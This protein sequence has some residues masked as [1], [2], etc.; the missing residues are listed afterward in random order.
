MPR[1]TLIFGNGLGMALAPQAY[2]LD[3]ALR[4]IWEDNAFLSGEQKGLIQACLPEGTEFDRPSDENDLD[5]LQRVLS[6]CDFLDEFD[7]VEGAHWLSEHGRSFP[8]AIRRF[9]HQVAACFHATGFELPEDFT[10]PL[11]DFLHNTKSHV[12]TL[13]YDPL[14]YDCFLE[15]NVLAGYRGDLIDGITNYGFQKENL[16]RHHPDNLGWYLHLHGSP[17]FYD[18][19]NGRVKKLPRGRLNEAVVESTHLVLT[20]V[21]HKASIISTSP[22]LSEYWKFLARALTESEEVLL[23]GYSGYDSHLNSFISRR[24]NGFE[25][26]VVEWIG[27]QPDNDRDAFWSERLRAQV[28]VERHNSILDFSAW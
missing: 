1:K 20:H 19:P 15:R 5:V 11:C 13:N 8:P 21:R 7:D 28:A 27:A 25:L 10:I 6:A 14:L 4:V 17:L 24:N 23:V 18:A 3:R 12:A 16:Y 9:I 22:L 2:S 26:R